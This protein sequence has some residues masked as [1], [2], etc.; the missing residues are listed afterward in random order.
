MKLN[1]KITIIL[2]LVILAVISLL[3]VAA[4]YEAPEAEV[5]LEITEQY[6]VDG[7]QGQALNR[8]DAHPIEGLEQS[9]YILTHPGLVA[10]DF[11]DVQTYGDLNN[12]EVQTTADDTVT[13]NGL[14]QLLENTADRLQVPTE[15]TNDIDSLLVLLSQDQSTT[16]VNTSSSSESVIGANTNHLAKSCVAAGG[17]WLAEHLECEYISQEWCSEQS[18]NFQECSSACRHQPDAQICTMQCVPVCQL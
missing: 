2:A 8:L 11:R 15:T 13:I 3:Y 14:V 5:S 4:Q 1:K 10:N 17:T 6:F 7:I 18:G 16:P 12:A 9:M